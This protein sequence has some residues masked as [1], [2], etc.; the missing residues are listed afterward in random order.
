ML[1]LSAVLREESL[2][3][4]IWENYLSHDVAYFSFFKTR[5]YH[6]EPRHEKTNNL[7]MR[8]QRRGPAS[9]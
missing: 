1:F 7:H 6:L 9:R 4:L 5:K 2:C 8:K 3:L